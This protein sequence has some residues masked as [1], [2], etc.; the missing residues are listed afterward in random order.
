MKKKHVYFVGAIIHQDNNILIMRE[1]DQPS[2]PTH[3]YFFPGAKMVKHVAP[4]LLLIEELKAKYGFMIAIEEYIGESVVETLDQIV[5][6]HAY[7][8]HFLTKP[9]FNHKQIDYRFVSVNDLLSYFL[10][11]NDH[12]IAERV[13]YFNDVYNLSLPSINKD[14]RSNQ[15]LWFYYE[16]L[17]Y[18]KKRMVKKDYEDIVNLIYTDCDNKKF[19]QAYKWIL[20]QNHL[21][22]N[23]YLDHVD[24]LNYLKKK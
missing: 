14:Y 12:I 2:L 23:E 20:K 6:L 5:H 4:D 9:H 3:P 19:R 22:Y 1:F 10:D 8:A 7:Y 18:Y 17:C 11:S 16:S 24:Y 13:Y 15:E 21:D